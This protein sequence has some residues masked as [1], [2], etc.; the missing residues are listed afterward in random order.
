MVG[1]QID[2]LTS[3]PSFGHNLYFEYSNGMCEPILDIYI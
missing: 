1:S 2:N 3:G